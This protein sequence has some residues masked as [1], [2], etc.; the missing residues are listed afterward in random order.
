MG[1]ELG[2]VFQVARRRCLAVLLVATSVAAVARAQISPGKLSEVHASLDNPLKCLQ[3]HTLGAGKPKPRCTFCHEEI[4]RRV[5]EGRGYHVRAMKGRTGE[6]PCAE[7][8]TEH[9]GRIFSIITW[10]TSKDEFDHRQ[11]GYALQGKHSRLR[12]EQCHQA[13]FIPAAER[14]LLKRKNLNRTLLG[15]SPACGSCHQ[16]LHQGE[17]G[18][19]CAKCHTQN[20]WKPASGFQHDAAKFRLTGLHVRVAC[21]KCH[22]SPVE[23]GTKVR[24]TGVSF[25]DCVPCHQDPHRGAIRQ[26][27]DSCHT[28]A[29]WKKLAP[30]GS[31]AHD[32][33]SFPLRGK[34]AAVACL[35]CHKTADFH[36][37]LPHALC[38]DCHRDIHNGQ[39][40]RRTDRG[41]CKGCHTEE[42]FVPA[43]FPVSAHQKTAYPLTGKHVSVRCQRCHI[44]AGAAT[45]YHPQHER[46]INC[47]PDPHAGQF[48]GAP[49]RNRCE[50]CHDTKGFRPSTYTLAQHRQSR[51]PLPGAHAAVACADCHRPSDTGAKPAARFHFDNQEC[52]VCHTD[53]HGVASGLRRGPA[54]PC[55]I[56]HTQNS[57]RSV[58]GFDHGRTSFPLDGAHRAAACTA[59][60]KPA[61]MRRGVRAIAFAPTSSLCSECHEDP[62]AGQFR[63]HPNGSACSLCHTTMRWKPSLFN[64]EKQAAFALT[65]IHRE[66]PCAMCHRRKTEINGVL[67]L[68]YRD[69]P[70]RC[71]A[72]H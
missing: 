19:D 46:C 20:S 34:H 15:L 25:S 55:S 54:R 64:H 4:R 57:W 58:L 26:R 44:P 28:A 48:A 37:R 61:G 33:T 51:F 30:G 66:V 47:H 9:Y 63:N 50:S 70:R 39:F 23:G 8:H 59:C 21:A 65:G 49:W 36:A 5:K 1:P 32:K 12:C 16:D 6:R 11:T 40:A 18:A 17:L 3:C 42:K 53:P 71:A 60:H 67:V 7:C 14:A 56:C 45:N 27:C 38:L 52:V 72:C 69:T 13:K 10:P 22:K 24:Y 68:L 41:D 29:G 35:K 62:H 2:R 31:F 43:V